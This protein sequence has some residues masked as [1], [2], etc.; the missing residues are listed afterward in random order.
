[1][2]ITGVKAENGLSL[3]GRLHQKVRQIVGKHL[4]CALAGI[5]KNVTADLALDRRCNQAI[6]A[7]QNCRRNVFFG[8]AVVAKQDL[9]KQIVEHDLGC[10]ADVDLEEILLFAA[11]DREHSVRSHLFERLGV[12]V[13]LRVN[14][15]LLLC[16]LGGQKTEL[17]GQ[18]AQ[19]LTELG[20][21]GNVLRD[22]ILGTLESLFHACNALF[23]VN[24]CLGLHL[25]RRIV[26]RFLRVD[27]LSQGFKSLF[28][29]H[30]RTRLTVRTEG[31]VN[32][33][34]LG[35]RLC[36]RD[37]SLDLG[38]HL[39]LSRDQ[40]KD[41]LLAL[42]NVAQKGQSVVEVTQHAV[43]KASR[44]LFAV[45]RD[46]RDRVALVDQSNRL[47]DLLELEVEFLCKCFKNVHWSMGSFLLGYSGIKLLL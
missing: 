27:Q 18:T 21:V 26:G 31:T 29:S 33:V 43:V 9:C 40:I 15:I 16:C 1:M 19:F 8:R 25:D 7:V 44:H 34:H 20:V 36:R 17:K 3:Q 6:V 30:R 41:L 2:C 47:F 28:T 45:T 24:I 35:D 46:K 39:L 11:V 32:I 12:F 10:N 13:I 4:D 38:G 14:R 37:R 22:N 5:I 42:F 23:F